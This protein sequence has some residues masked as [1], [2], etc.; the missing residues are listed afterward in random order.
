MGSARSRSSGRPLISRPQPEVDYVALP[1]GLYMFP[2]KDGVVLGGT[3]QH[4]VSSLEPDLA[5]E[6]RILEGH[7]RFFAEL[8]AR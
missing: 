6:Q 3:F 1:L 4:H 5:A 2:R 8:E 7:A